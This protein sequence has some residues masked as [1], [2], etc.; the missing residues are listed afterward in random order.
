MPALETRGFELVDWQRS[1]VEA[2]RRGVDGEPFRGTLEVVTG[3]GKTLI[4]LSCA[5]LAF[6]TSPDLRVVVVV[7]TE[8]LARQWRDAVERY[9]TVPTA[10][11]GL[12]GAGGMMLGF[13]ALTRLPLPESVAIGYALP[14]LIVVFSALFAGETVRAYRWT[15]VAAGLVGVM[16]ILWPR[17]TVLTGG[18]PDPGGASLGAVAALCGC[19]F[20]A[21]ATVM[22]RNLVATERSATIV[23]YQ[24]LT[25][26]VVGLSGL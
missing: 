14:L 2:W 22:V 1:G 6:E 25:C 23:L 13:F 24:S 16:I 20:G 3:G 17:L 12:L 21:T 4:A 18:A 19:V 10:Q 7:P 15:A 26:A 8:A 9:T 11:I 5:A